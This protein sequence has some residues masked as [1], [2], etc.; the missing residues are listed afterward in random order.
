MR[1]KDPLDI[2]AQTDPPELIKA[3]HGW[4]VTA[5][6]RERTSLYRCGLC[7][8]PFE[9][10]PS[11]VRKQ[12]ARKMNVTC[13]CGIERHGASGT[14]LYH[15]LRDA[16][17]RCFNPDHKK[18]PAYGGRGIAVDDEWRYNFWVFKEW[19]LANGYRTD[20]RTPGGRNALTLDRIDVNGD[21]CPENCRWA[22]YQ[23]QA[24]NQRRSVPVRKIR[25]FDALI[26]SGLNGREAAYLMG[27][28]Y[29][30]AKSVHR[31]W[32]LSTFT[33]SGL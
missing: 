14:R 31:R 4:R 26:H 2:A 27:W 30:A 12:L 9:Q 33:E 28:G 11:Y 32:R 13:G 8:E 18:Y 17:S 19:A 24:R 7:D 3:K 23:E 21:Y 5:S 10:I 6:K 29:D 20:I 25:L 16:I 22:S 15:I 1:S